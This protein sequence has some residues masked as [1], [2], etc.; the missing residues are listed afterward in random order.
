MHHPENARPESDEVAAHQW[1][2]AQAHRLVRFRA[3]GGRAEE[4]DTICDEDG[5]I[6]PEPQDIAAA[7]RDRR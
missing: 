5:K 4:V 1:R 6:K 7:A 2:L 3:D